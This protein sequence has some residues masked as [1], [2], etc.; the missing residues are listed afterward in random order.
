MNINKSNNLPSQ[1]PSCNSILT[2]NSLICGSCSTIVQGNFSL[3]TLSRLSAN[4]QLLTIN[5]IKTGGSLKDLAKIYRISY[6]TIRNRIDEL[7]ER[8]IQLENDTA[9]SHLPGENNE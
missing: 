1:C 6:P 3:S 4:D 7:G 5:F 9:N 2:V 8:L